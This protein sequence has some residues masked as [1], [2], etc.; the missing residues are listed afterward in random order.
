MIG[1]RQASAAEAVLLFSSKLQPENGQKFQS[2]KAVLRT[3]IRI[4]ILIRIPDPGI[5]LDP[6]PHPGLFE[7]GF[8]PAP[9]LDFAKKF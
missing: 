5:F 8:N 3:W 1:C 7:S 6:N 4:C 2:A 9:G